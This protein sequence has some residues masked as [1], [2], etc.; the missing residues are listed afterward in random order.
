MV[1]VTQM[2]GPPLKDFTEYEGPVA[3]PTFASWN[4]D[5]AIASVQICVTVAFVYFPVELRFRGLVSL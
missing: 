2:L 5:H 3:F 4:R 1:T